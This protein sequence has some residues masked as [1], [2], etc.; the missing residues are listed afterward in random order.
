MAYRKEDVM[1]KFTIS[2]EITYIFAIVLMACAVS[3]TAAADFG[4]SMIVAP[5]Y[6][7]HLKIGFLSFGQCE[8]ILQAILFLLFCLLL[9]KVK[10][11]YFV[12]FGTCLLYGAILD[13]WRILIPLFNLTVTQPGSMSMWLRILLLLGGMVLTSLSV[14][15]LFRVYLH[16]QVYDF[17]VKGIS[18]HFGLDRTKFKIGFDALCLI[19]SVILS[20]I[21]FGKLNGIGIGTVI[22]TFCN[23]PLIGLLGKI[24]DQYMLFTPI[25]PDFA[26]KI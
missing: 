13:G 2:S 16:P 1:R 6:M 15:L 24:L 25:F 18:A 5:A 20:L 8:Y 10:V 11:I 26:K 14:A 12:S 4:V 7:V 22:M 9:K 19:L 21:F 23:G 17:F 3:M